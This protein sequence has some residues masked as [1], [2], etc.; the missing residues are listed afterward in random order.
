MFKVSVIIPIYNVAEFVEQ[1]VES[2]VHLLEVAEIILVEDGSPDNSLEVCLELKKMYNKIKVFQHFDEKNKGISAS[3]NLGIMEAESKYI[4]F[5]DADDWYLPHRF[6]KDKQIFE[7]IDSI[8]AVYSTTI[9]EE[10]VGNNDLRYGIT[11]NPKDK[12]GRCSEPM[13]FYKIKTEARNVLFHTNSI[14]IRKEFL[15]KDKLFDTRLKLHE[16]SELWNRLLRRGCFE[17]SEWENP[18]AVIRRHSKN[19]IIK[20]NWKSHLKMIAVQIDNIGLENLQTFEIVD[21]YSRVIRLQSKRFVNHWIRRVYFYSSYS[22]NFFSKKSFL[23][24][25]RKAYAID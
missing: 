13:E 19:N 25:I 12:W 22:F 6:K 11:F 15:V 1:A 4:A 5:L 10:H 20:R 23:E 24:K 9:L 3:R 8:D 18:V 14:T 16:D 2:A 21:L 17:A 7:T